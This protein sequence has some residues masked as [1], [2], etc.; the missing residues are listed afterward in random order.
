MVTKKNKI[1]P[2]EYRRILETLDLSRIWLE[3][4][5][6]NVNR[7]NLSEKLAIGFKEKYTYVNTD[8]GARITAVV[9]LNAGEKSRGIAIKIM[10]QFVLDFNTPDTLTDDF[11][12]IYQD[13]SLPFI[14]WPFFR[15]YVY[16]ITS[17]MEIPPLT[18]PQIHQ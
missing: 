13:I 11:F 17:R 18:L 7:E 16:S 9:S 10:G 14:V 1:S 12:E 3:N 8:A 4:G 15:E 5:S 6:F 2:D